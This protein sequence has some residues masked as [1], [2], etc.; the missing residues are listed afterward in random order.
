VKLISEYLNKL[1]TNMDELL[2]K[3][4][5]VTYDSIDDIRIGLLRFNKAP[6]G[7][8]FLFKFPDEQIRVFHTIGM[9]FPI[10][11]YFFDKNKELVYSYGEVKPGL[12]DL[13][14]KK[15]FMYVVEIP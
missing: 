9:K 3:S 12:D 1:N 2:S 8:A 7:K 4:K 14:Y 10:K 6:K 15:P 13:T 11:I 5:V